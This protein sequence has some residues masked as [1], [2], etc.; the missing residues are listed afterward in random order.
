MLDF[1]GVPVKALELRNHVD[2]MRLL[3]DKVRPC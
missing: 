2:R 1:Y 3:A